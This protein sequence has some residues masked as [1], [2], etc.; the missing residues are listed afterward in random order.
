MAN[1]VLA[2]VG[3]LFKRWSGTEWQPMAEVRAIVGPSANKDTV[4]VTHLASLDGT[5][6]FISGFHN[7]GTVALRMGF[8]RATYEIMK[9]DFET[10]TI[11][12]YSIQFPGSDEIF[13]DFTGL[14]T[15]LPVDIVSDDSVISNVEI[16]ITGQ[17]YLATDE[18][19]S[20]EAL[21]SYEEPSEVVPSEDESV[22]T[23]SEELS[24]TLLAKFAMLW[25]GDISGNNLLNALDTDYIIVT[26]KDFATD[27]IPATSAATFA[28]PNTAPYIAADQDYLWFDSGGS[29]RAVTVA[30]LIGYDFNRTFVMYA[31]SSPYH[32]YAIGVLADG[33][34][35]TESDWN[36]LHAFFD[37]SIFYTGELNLYGHLKENRTIGKSEW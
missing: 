28:L 26:G 22:V 21:P 6:E 9:E 24:S 12:Y 15:K 33:E 3:T 17:F 37:L 5:R 1:D 32:I 29:P 14:V 23:S 30:E 20:S 2:G 7:G 36:E 27:Y 25:V 13:I 34:T 31:D 4:D 8:S 10:N 19:P 18:W 16:Q 11:Q 35:L